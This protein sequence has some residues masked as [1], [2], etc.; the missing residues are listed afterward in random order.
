MD[1]G[2][3]T[4]AAG[5]EPGATRSALDERV[6][7]VLAAGDPVEPPPSEPTRPNGAVRPRLRDGGARAF[8]TLAFLIALAA[9][10]DTCQPRYWF[11]TCSLHGCLTGT[12]DMD[13][14][15]RCRE[16]SANSRRSRRSGL[17]ETRLPA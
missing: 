4:P 7:R 1:E 6:A 3:T 12:I 8:A 13:A 15:C 2:V 14:A 17:G 16:Q 11:S 5:N 9:A 10:T